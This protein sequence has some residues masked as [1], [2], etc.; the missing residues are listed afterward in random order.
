MGPAKERLYS[1][2]ITELSLGIN[3]VL[4]KFCRK[5][6]QKDRVIPL[7]CFS[8]ADAQKAFSLCYL[9]MTL[10][11]FRLNLQHDIL[12]QL[13][14]RIFSVVFPKFIHL[15]G[16]WCMRNILK[17]SFP[18][19]RSPLYIPFDNVYLITNYF[20]E[21]LLV[22]VRHWGQFFV[23]LF[24]VCSGS[25]CGTYLFLIFLFL[26][27]SMMDKTRPTT[28]MTEAITANPLNM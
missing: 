1:D 11:H 17:T 9:E 12:Q 28:I 20:R 23:I 22:C 26:N 3:R 7:Q 6:P 19:F 21:N 4:R 15:K 2:S 16:Y 10:F 8:P 5:L 27:V 13:L 24:C 25:L 18:L 14:F